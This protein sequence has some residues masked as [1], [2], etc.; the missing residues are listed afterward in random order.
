MEGDIVTRASLARSSSPITLNDADPLPATT[1]NNDP[2]EDDDAEF[3]K[4]LD[5]GMEASL[6][7][8]PSAPPTSGPNSSMDEDEDMWDIVNEIEQETS[9]TATAPDAV[10]VALGPL[11]E[12]HLQDDNW[13]DMYE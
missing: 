5:A 13:D 8:I 6:S 1:R 12:N 9:N 4:T 3:W 10:T 2:P 7:D 11:P